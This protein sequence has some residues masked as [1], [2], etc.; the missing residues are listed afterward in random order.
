L[1]IGGQINLGGVPVNVHG[2]DRLQQW[3]NKAAFQPAPDD[4]RGTAGLDRSWALGVTSG[5][6]PL[7]KRIS[8]GEKVR[9]QFQ[10]DFFNAF[11]RLNLNDP[12]YYLWV[13]NQPESELWHHFGCCTWPQYSAGSEGDILM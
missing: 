7:R 3:F 6:S 10:A 13:S 1:V 8:V 9:L 2:S 11:N 5:T 4:R 12:K